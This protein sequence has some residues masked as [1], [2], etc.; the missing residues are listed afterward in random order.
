MLRG[1]RQHIGSEVNVYDA[2]APVGRAQVVSL[3][4]AAGIFIRASFPK[5][6]AR[7]LALLR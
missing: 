6:Y 3:P 5:V 1:G 4:A 7:A 2:G